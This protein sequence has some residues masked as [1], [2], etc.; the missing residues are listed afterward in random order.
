[1]LPLILIFRSLVQ[2]GSSTW[3][4]RSSALN[5]R[6]RPSPDEFA[7][8]RMEGY[9]HYHGEFV[10]TDGAWFIAKLVQT[11]LRLDFTY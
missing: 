6:S 1:V 2:S 11:R 8:T 7:F 9:G 4:T 3:T 10:K 5:A